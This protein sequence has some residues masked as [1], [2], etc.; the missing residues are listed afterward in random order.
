MNECTVETLREEIGDTNSIVVDVREPVEFAGGRIANSKLIPLGQITQRIS[1]LDGDSNIYLICRTG[2]RSGKAQKILTALG[3]DNTTNVKGGFNAWKAAEYPF[4]QDDKA[5]WDIERQVRFVAGLLILTGFA[6]SVLIHPYL[7]GL[8]V[9]VGA[10]LTFSALT[11]T[12]TMGMI[13]MKMPWNRVSSRQ[14]AGA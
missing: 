12:C 9:F 8:S 6:L 2:N 3:F 10:G 11:N 14:V 5:P 7:I 13:L 1:E 4:E